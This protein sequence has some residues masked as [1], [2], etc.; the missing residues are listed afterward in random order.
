MM[1][2][3]K[4]CRM[5]LVSAFIILGLTFAPLG[6]AQEDTS[7]KDLDAYIHNS[8]DSFRWDIVSN[9][10]NE[11]GINCVVNMTS[12]TWHDIA[13]KHTMYIVEPVKLTNP[14]HCVLFIT[15]VF[16]PK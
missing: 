10:R 12:Q 5:K 8:D 9:S 11:N 2:F 14:E 4:S 7:P 15:G 6:Y 1:S 3:L 16:N 13:W